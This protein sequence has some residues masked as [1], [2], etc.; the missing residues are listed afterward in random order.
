V[1]VVRA[2]RGHQ[3]RNVRVGPVGEVREEVCKSRATKGDQRKK[4]GKV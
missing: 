3:G 2:S 1:P 4:G